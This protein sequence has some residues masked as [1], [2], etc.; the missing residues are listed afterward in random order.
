MIVPKSLLKKEYLEIKKSQTTFH[1]FYVKLP[2]V[3]IWQQ[4]NKFPLTC[5]S[6]KPLFLV[7]KC[8]EKTALQK[9]AC[10]ENKL[11]PQTQSNGFLSQSALG[12]FTSVHLLVKFTRVSSISPNVSNCAQSREIFLLL[13]F[14]L[15]PLEQIGEGNKG[16]DRYEFKLKRLGGKNK[17]RTS[18]R[19]LLLWSRDTP[20]MGVV[21]NI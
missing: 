9:F 5:S 19:R 12:K 13:V 17:L 7:K 6:L 14:F 1:F 4:S 20:N 18:F 16:N 21:R 8:F 2:T 10:F 11:R 15:K 3:Q